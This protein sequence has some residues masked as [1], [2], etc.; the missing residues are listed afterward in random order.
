MQTVL[1]YIFHVYVIYRYFCT[2]HYFKDVAVNVQVNYY[3]ISEGFPI[4]PCSELGEVDFLG[5][6]FRMGTANPFNL[7]VPELTPV[8]T[9]S[10]LYTWF[11]CVLGVNVTEHKISLLVCRRKFTSRFHVYHSINL[12]TPVGSV[13][14]RQK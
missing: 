7:T 5:S 13:S 4:P 14:I 1:W 8:Q 12:E 2:G 11:E 9:V 3:F 10:F 6:V